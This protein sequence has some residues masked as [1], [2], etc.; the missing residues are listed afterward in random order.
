MRF[1]SDLFAKTG[2]A[3]TKSSTF[4]NLQGTTVS[5]ATAGPQQYIDSGPREPRFVLVPR[6]GIS[7]S[8]GAPRIPRN[9]LRHGL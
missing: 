1:C 5:P 2:A 6:A 9:M 4:A 3:F 8:L 7:V